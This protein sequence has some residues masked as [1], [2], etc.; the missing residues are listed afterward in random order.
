MLDEDKGTGRYGPG[1]PTNKQTDKFNCRVLLWA[2]TAAGRPGAGRPGWGH[3]G[4]GGRQ[5]WVRVRFKQDNL[6]LKIETYQC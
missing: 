6:N 2:E 4:A 3:W 5:W 1:R